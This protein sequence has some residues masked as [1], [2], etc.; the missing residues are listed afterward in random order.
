MQ[1]GF[2][3]P[4][5]TP[6]LPPSIHHT[7]TFALPG[8]APPL[9]AFLSMA[10]HGECGGSSSPADA[11]QPAACNAR[12][13]RRRRSPCSAAPA[14]GASRVP[15]PCTR[16]L[17]GALS[18]PCVRCTAAGEGQRNGSVGNQKAADT[19]S[20]AVRTGRLQRPPALEPARSNPRILSVSWGPHK[21]IKRKITHTLAG[22]PE[23]LF[24]YSCFYPAGEGPFRA[25]FES[26]G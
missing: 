19:C 13:R 9:E 12:R 16:R 1:F 17:G 8:A 15:S 4:T 22:M 18:W 23:S 14:A 5:N 7:C 10:Q 11:A 2:K 25:G 6:R 21:K 24:V 3:T 20:T 26:A